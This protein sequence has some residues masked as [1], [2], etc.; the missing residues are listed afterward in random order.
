MTQRRGLIYA[1]GAL[2]VAVP[3]TF[4]LVSTLGS[5]PAETRAAPTVTMPSDVRNAAHVE[6][7]AVDPVALID[8]GWQRYRDNVAA[9]S[10]LLVKQERLADGLT[11]VQQVEVR[12]REEPHTVYMLW[13]QN[14][15]EVKRAL[16]QDSPEFVDPQGRKQARVEPAGAIARLFVKDLMIDIHGE[17]ARKNSRRTIDECGF[18]A[19]FE[20]LARYNRLAAERGVLDLRYAG[21]GVIDGRPTHVLK[22]DLPYQGVDGPFPDARMVM[23]LD[24]EW[25]L[26][27]AIYSYADHQEQELLGS[28]VFKNVRLNPQFGEDAFEF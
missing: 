13:Q 11:P 12:F 26:P 28:Y 27:V 16:F 15:D 17:R 3:P 1:V 2:V 5:V 7:T 20:L 24:Q 4:W 14:P 10:C 9:Y 8:R 6:V 19:T 18:G 21:T 23:H 22:R 25:L